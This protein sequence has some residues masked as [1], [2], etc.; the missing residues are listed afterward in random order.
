M[1]VKNQPDKFM[2]YTEYKRMWTRRNRASINAAKSKKRKEDPSYYWTE[3]CRRVLIQSFKEKYRQSPCENL[4]GCSFDK[5]CE[6][7]QSQ[8]ED[9][10][11]WD[12]RGYRGW[13]IDHIIPCKCFDMT[14]ISQR[15]K[16]FHYTN[17]RPRWAKDNQNREYHSRRRN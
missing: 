9:G 2:A 15:H 13:Q 6:H 1:A 7:L 8:F 10:M 12:N 17:L 14:D 3:R 5:L 16:C 11:N 4:V